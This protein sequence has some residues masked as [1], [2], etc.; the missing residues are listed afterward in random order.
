[1]SINDNAVQSP[2]YGSARNNV[3]PDV[4]LELKSL[5]H[6]DKSTTYLKTVTVLT[7]TLT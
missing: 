5:S 4:S 6:T 3:D 7:W 1:M 2:S